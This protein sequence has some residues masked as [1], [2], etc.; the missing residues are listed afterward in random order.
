MGGDADRRPGDDRDR[1]RRAAQPEPEGGPDQ[2]GERDVRDR[3]VD[4]HRDHAE[5]GH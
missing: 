5:G 4:A 1:K 3:L 2:R